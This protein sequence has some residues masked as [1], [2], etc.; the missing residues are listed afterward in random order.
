MN[1]I[2]K[3]KWNGHPQPLGSNSYD[4]ARI[5]VLNSLQQGGCTIGQFEIMDN[6]GILKTNIIYDKTADPTL[7]VN[8][9]KLFS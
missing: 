5:Y 6:W 1:N 8:Y 7:T 9:Q 2:Y 3:V 4:S